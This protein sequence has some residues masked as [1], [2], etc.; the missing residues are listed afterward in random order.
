MAPKM[1][2]STEWLAEAVRD[3]RERT[4]EIVEDLSDEQLMGPRLSMVNPLRWEIGHLAW[5]QEFWALS[6]GGRLP[7]IRADADS[8]YDS[9]KVPHDARWDLPLPSRGETLDY[10]RQVRKRVLERLRA[11]PAPE[12]LYFIALS[13]DAPTTIPSVTPAMRS[14]FP[15][16]PIPTTRPSRMPTSAFTIPQ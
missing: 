6:H 11:N 8:L 2:Y 15:A 5:F 12:E 9:I 10:L 14:G 3:A 13:V 16:L 4:F 7:S 1:F